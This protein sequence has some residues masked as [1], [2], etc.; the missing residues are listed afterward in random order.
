MSRTVTMKQALLELVQ[1]AHKDGMS[2]SPKIPMIAM[3]P[4]RSQQYAHLAVT[5]FLERDDIV[6]DEE[7]DPAIEEVEGNA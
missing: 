7:A 1:Q 4:L 5:A 6:D 2:D 3:R